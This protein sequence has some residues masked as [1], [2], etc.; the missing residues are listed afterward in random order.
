M[1]I[2]FITAV[3]PYPLHSGGQI[4]IYN[5]LK[6]LSKR[7]NITLVTFIRGHEELAYKDALSFCAGV[8]M[9]MR[10][11]A[12]Q[13][14]YVMRSVTGKYPFL[15]ATYENYAMRRQIGD[16]LDTGTYDLVHAEPFYV[17]PSIPA[18]TLPCVVSEHNI[19]YDVYTAYVSRFSVRILK[20]ILY[21]DVTKLKF[22]ERTVWKQADAV[23]AVSA[24]DA[25]V[26][27][28]GTGTDV[29]VVP[30]GVDTDVFRSG[31]KQVSTDPTF[32]F[33]GNFRW[34]PN[35]DAAEMLIE[36][37]WPLLK[38]RYPNSRLRIVGRD[39]SGPLAAKIKMSGALIST[40]VTDITSSYREADFLIAP[41]AI[42]GGTKF[43][44]LEAMASGTAVITTPEGI[45]GLGATTGEHY[46]TARTPQEYA[47]AVTDLWQHPEKRK[48]ITGNARKFVV[49]RF[50][51]KRSAD[52]LDTVWK[53]AY[54]SKK[55]S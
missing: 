7:H 26:I 38:E 18:H 24:E 16:L 41:H 1:N 54:E 39:I 35:R 42:S 48:R 28:S 4:R 23:T 36:H 25:E 20:P 49:D 6:L 8:H 53:K 10:G 34:L 29:S 2:L 13:A 51:W 46:V 52:T 44:M 21:W 45:A 30:N 27:A 43:K 5:L 3:C 19:E 22:W 33:V 14:R 47:D 55:R 40:D 50:D 37:I 32:L 15:L 9:V 17:W 12:W 31:R 11:R